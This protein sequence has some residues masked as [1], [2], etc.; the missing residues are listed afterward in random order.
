MMI[1]NI[2]TSLVMISFLIY[3]TISLELSPP[4]SLRSFRRTSTSS[5][6]SPNT[7]HTSTHSS[8]VTRNL[9]LLVIPHQTTVLLEPR[10]RPCQERGEK[11]RMLIAVFSAP[12]HTLA[13][14]VVRRTWAKN[15]REV[16]GVELVFFLGRDQDNRVEVS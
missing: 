14:S 9:S 2:L 3:L 16:S 5:Q 4:S 1:I 11:L 13:R 8:P 12:S 7:S 15:L 6:A 10:P